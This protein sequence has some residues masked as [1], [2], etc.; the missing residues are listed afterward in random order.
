MT[1][2]GRVRRGLDVACG[3]GPSTSALAE[4]ADV[5]IGVDAAEQMVRTATTA[6]G[7]GCRYLVAEAEALPFAGSCFDLV[8]VGSAVHW[9]DQS[10]FCAEARRVLQPGGRLVVYEH[11]FL[12][13]IEESD[14]FEGWMRDRY[15]DRFPIPP[16]G[17]HPD[18]EW[19]ANGFDKLGREEYPDGVAMIRSQLVDYLMSQ[20]NTVVPVD[21]GEVTSAGVAGWLETE[22]VE[23]FP[24][25]DS[26]TMRFWGVV[27]V[28]RSS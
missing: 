14:A 5:A 10:R 17:R 25:D 13:Q 12:G 6:D 1:G 11:H 23:Y 15:L 20:S 7:A 8:S 27:N 24:D 9:F 16:R 28:F 26:R 18:P 22:L 21:R 19:E 4:I 2:D 3:P